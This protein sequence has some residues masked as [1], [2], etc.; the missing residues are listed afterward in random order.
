MCQDPTGGTWNRQACGPDEGIGHKEDTNT[1]R[2]IDG[3][4]HCESDAIKE[5]CKAN[6]VENLND[7]PYGKAYAQVNQK[8]QDLLAMLKEL[9]IIKTCL[10]S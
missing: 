7:V 10:L 3:F 8:M 9:L 1:I 5:V 6:S 4:E 2:F